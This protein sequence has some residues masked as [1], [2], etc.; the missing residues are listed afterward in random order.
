M[1]VAHDHVQQRPAGQR[2]Q[3]R[4]FQH[5]ETAPGLLAGGLRIGFLVVRRVGQL[6]RT[7]IHHLYWAALQARVRTRPLIRR[8]GRG[9][10]HPFQAFLRQTLAGLDVS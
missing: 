2:E 6:H 1:Q 3:H 4:Q 9:R 8:P 10:Q 5:G 7:A